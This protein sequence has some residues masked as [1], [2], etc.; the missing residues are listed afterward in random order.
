MDEDAGQP[1]GDGTYGWSLYN[2]S[3]GGPTTATFPLPPGTPITVNFMLID[4][5][6]GPVVF[7]RQIV[8]SQCDGGT[9][10]SD[11]ILVGGPPGIAGLDMVPIPD[12]AVVGSFVTTTPIYF[13]PRADAATATVMEAGKTAYVYGVD[14]SGGFYKVML[15]GQFF[16]VPVNTMGPNF[17]S[18][19][20]GRPL[21]TNV[22]D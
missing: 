15:S 7:H 11:Q 9:I 3:S 5:I 17:D 22:V 14:A 18:V 19:W 10:I 16:W 20:N 12:T 13:E 4:G 1:G 6:G 21:P 8:I 2:S